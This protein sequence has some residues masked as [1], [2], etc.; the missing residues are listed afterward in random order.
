MVRTLK[1]LLV[2]A[3]AA[4]L[5]VFVACS[6]SSSGG[7]NSNNAD[8]DQGGVDSGMC[9]M[10]PAAAAAVPAFTSCANTSSP[11]VSFQKDIRPIFEQ[12]C[13][14][15]AS[16]HGQKSGAIATSGLI[17]LGASDGGTD[18][19]EILQGIVGVGSPENTSQSIVKAGDPGNSYMMHKLDSDMC[20]YVNACNATKVAAFVEC[21]LGMPYASPQLCLDSQTDCVK[22]QSITQQYGERDQIRRWI[23]QGAKNN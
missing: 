18:A 15:T 10:D 7:G 12:S 9:P 4:P 6:S 19:A 8:C 1:V 13:S 3:A 11:E 14:I 20:Q 23:A 21:G 5:A 16:C 22:T 2:L 17:Y